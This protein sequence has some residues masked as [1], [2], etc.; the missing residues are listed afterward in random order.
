[1]TLGI[2][3]SVRVLEQTAFVERKKVINRVIKLYPKMH[4]KLLS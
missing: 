1:M 4:H 3:T 2:F